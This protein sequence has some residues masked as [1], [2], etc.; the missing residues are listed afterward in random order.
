MWAGELGMRT[1]ISGAPRLGLIVL[2]FPQIYPFDS[3][4]SIY[5]RNCLLMPHGE[6]TRPRVQFFKAQMYRGM[7]R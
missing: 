6:A 1:S 7:H 4:K 5:Q 2:I 3:V